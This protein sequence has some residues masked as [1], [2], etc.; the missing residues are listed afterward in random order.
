ML[1]KFINSPFKQLSRANA[2]TI[3][4]E[5]L[6]LAKRIR[7]RGRRNPLKNISHL[8]GKSSC[9]LRKNRENQKAAIMRI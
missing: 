2:G 4:E 8:L 6:H 5:V 7:I 1:I 3:G 9:T